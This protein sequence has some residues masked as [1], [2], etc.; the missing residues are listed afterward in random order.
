MDKE[1]IMT[2]SYISILKSIS[3]YMCKRNQDLGFRNA[4]VEKKLDAAMQVL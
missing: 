1:Q 3:V 2:D 4:T